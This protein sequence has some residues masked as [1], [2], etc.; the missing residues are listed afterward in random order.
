M[1][2]PRELSLRKEEML[3]LV[4]SESSLE[5]NY[6]ILLPIER[7]QE[8]SVVCYGLKWHRLEQE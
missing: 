1:H 2:C 6:E 3:S 4:Y 5:G 7:S 8:V